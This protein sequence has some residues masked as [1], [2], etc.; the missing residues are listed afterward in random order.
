[1]GS[2]NLS[3][4]NQR[5]YDFGRG[6]ISPKMTDDDILDAIS[7]MDSVLREHTLDTAVPEFDEQYI[8]YANDGWPRT[9]ELWRLMRD[10]LKQDD[11][12]D[13]IDDNASHGEKYGVETDDDDDGVTEVQ[14]EGDDSSDGPK[15]KAP[16]S[17]KLPK[18]AETIEVTGGNENTNF[19]PD[20][21]INKFLGPISA[22]Q[23]FHE[24][25]VD[26]QVPP[27]TI[28]A[29]AL[30][31]TGFNSGQIGKNNF[32]N[33][34]FDKSLGCDDHA[35]QGNKC[36]FS[37]ARVGIAGILKFI[38][39][40]KCSGTLNA[41]SATIENDDQ[42]AKGTT[43]QN[44]LKVLNHA[45]MN[46]TALN[47]VEQYKL[48][49]WDNP[50]KR[51]AEPDPATESKIAGLMKRIDQLKFKYGV[52]FEVKRSGSV[53]TITR[54]PKNKTTPCEPVY[55]DLITVADTIPEWIMTQTTAD[56]NKKAEE[57]ARRAAG[58]KDKNADEQALSDYEDE[59][60]DFQKDQFTAWVVEKGIQVDTDDAM[61]EAKDK[62]EDEAHNTENENFINGIYLPDEAS[63]NKYNMLRQ[64]I[65][66]VKEKIDNRNA[67]N[68]AWEEAAEKVGQDAQARDAALSSADAKQKDDGDN[69]KDDKNNKDNNN[70]KND[71]SP[72]E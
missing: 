28:L 27:S 20:E 5:A 26:K 10:W 70:D 56:I 14:G 68:R 45:D 32:W 21:Y 30:A 54:L 38:H 18:Q 58:L 60:Q 31:V 37:D 17:S 35:D 63:K 36:A 51:D 62:Y 53:S 69:N 64:R 7:K 47:N 66:K 12:D 3:Y 29:V 61:K 16:S 6:S 33:L 15:N 13:I 9:A 25:N 8:Q 49:N 2:W 1:M 39:S 4:F 72:S 11:V 22:N 24:E 34:D 19:N 65:E 50:D 55:P 40:E 67:M 48:T 44:F 23:C 43:I 57:E 71:N 46:T 41:L 42:A 59:M 52:G